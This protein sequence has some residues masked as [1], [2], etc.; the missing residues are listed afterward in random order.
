[1]HAWLTKLDQYFPVRYTVWLLTIAGLLLFGF[2]WVAFQ[3]NGLAALVCL[4]GVQKLTAV[5][6]VASG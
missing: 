3:A 4:Y 1:M 2:T 5:T 6:V